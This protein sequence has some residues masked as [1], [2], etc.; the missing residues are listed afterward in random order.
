MPVY[1]T[2]TILACSPSKVFDF[3]ARPANLAL[4]TPPDLN[5]KLVAGPERL[6]LG[7]TITLQGSKFGISQ[8]ITSEVTAFEE[9]VRF[10][11]RQISGP[12]GKFEH[13]HRL[14]PHDDG[15][16][17]IDRIEYES[18]GG[19]VGLYLTNNR[20]RQDLEALTAFRTERFKAILES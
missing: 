7:S 13:T 3:L 10:T 12:F 6:A 11:D 9:G 20:I 14:E 18:P 15:T 4:V 1:E 2:A 5:M 19:L 16:R 8:K 17:M